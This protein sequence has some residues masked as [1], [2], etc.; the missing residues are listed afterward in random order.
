M[1]WRGCLHK[2]HKNDENVTMSY[3]NIFFITLVIVLMSVGTILFF[4]YGTN[5]AKN[6]LPP[7]M[8]ATVQAVYGLGTVKSDLI[9]DLRVGTTVTIAK[10]FVR[11]GDTVQ[12]G[13]A[14]L[15]LS[16]H[17]L[18]TAPFSGK[19][20]KLP[21]HVGE[22]VFAQTSLLTLVNLEARYVVVS[23]EQ[24]G[25]TLVR[26]NQVAWLSFESLRQ[27]KVLG[28]V[29][30]VYPSDGEFLVRIASS[31]IPSEILPGMTADVAI[32]IQRAEGR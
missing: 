27:E 14:L 22:T 29:E 7:Q 16:N 15:E 18:F 12:V 24:K 17:I 3:R 20:T 13:G 19:V 6:V 23:L 5:H 28:R 32:E 31:Q 10:L 30:S 1:A 25:T 2:N 21:F 11:E 26:E 9:Y 8:E 4:R